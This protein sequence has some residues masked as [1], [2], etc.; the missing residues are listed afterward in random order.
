MDVF[1][2]HL[3]VIRAVR[4]SLSSFHDVRV[5]QKT[6]HNEAFL[7]V[8]SHPTLTDKQVE[9][10]LFQVLKMVGVTD[11]RSQFADI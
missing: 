10:S 2:L 7:N 6:P 5:A 11:P 3:A 4:I 1:F 9:G 8:H